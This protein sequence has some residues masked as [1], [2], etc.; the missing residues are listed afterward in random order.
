MKDDRIYLLHARDA[1]Q[2]IVDYTA[3]GKDGFFSDRK[4]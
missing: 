4:T 3:A 1:I 2:H